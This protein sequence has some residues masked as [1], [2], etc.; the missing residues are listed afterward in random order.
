MDRFPLAA[1]D[2]PKSDRLPVQHVAIALSGLE[3]MI[4]RETDRHALE[5]RQQHLQVRIPAR[6]GLRHILVR[7]QAQGQ[8]QV[9]ALVHRHQFPAQ[10]PFR[11]A[12]AAPGILEQRRWIEFSHRAVDGRA[13]VAKVD[14][15]GPATT[16]FHLAR[17]QPSGQPTGIREHVPD[18]LAAVSDGSLQPGLPVVAPAHDRCRHAR[19]SS[20][21]V[22]VR[23]CSCSGPL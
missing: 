6:G 14:L 12:A 9:R 20:A 13:A 2:E 8:G 16:R 7:G 11:L 1:V 15:H 10:R 17:R 19:V 21:V 4:D 22:A 23:G 18:G 3:E 5:C